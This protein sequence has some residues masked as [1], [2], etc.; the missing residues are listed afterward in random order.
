MKRMLAGWWLVLCAATVAS[1]AEPRAVV[2]SSV[3]RVMAILTE[4]ELGE[5]SSGAA[6]REHAEQRRARIRSV[7]AVLFDFEEIA[8]RALARHWAPLS[9]LERAEFTRLF[10][11]VLEHAYVARLEDYS[12]ER[13]VWTGE[14]VEAG[15]AA[16]RSKVVTRRGEVG[17]EYRLHL[18]GGRW[19]VYDLRIGGMS[20]VS[21]YRAQFD[22]ILRA[23][24]F[25]G[26][27]ERLRRKTF[28]T[29]VAGPG[30]QGL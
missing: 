21:V 7:A 10:T 5:P 6:A 2:Q 11:G 22:R 3:E 4:S 26:L 25:D 27:L 15:F 30:A 18:R 17:V 23:E 16:V 28:D 29:A 13:L 14:T 19:R 1:A 24:S 9:P 20:F 8:R 12:G